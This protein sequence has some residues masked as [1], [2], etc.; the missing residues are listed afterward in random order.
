[1]NLVNETNE[2]NG[3]TMNEKLGEYENRFDKTEFRLYEL[4]SKHTYFSNISR[5]Q[6]VLLQYKQHL[7]DIFERYEKSYDSFVE[8]ESKS[9]VVNDN[10]NRSR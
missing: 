9:Y 4:N 6:K 3:M 8:K 5:K 7:M 1:M 2:M 10:N